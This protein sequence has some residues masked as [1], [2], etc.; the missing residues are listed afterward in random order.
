MSYV[1]REIKIIEVQWGIFYFFINH[2][3]AFNIPVFDQENKL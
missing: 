3:C 1:Q 2:V